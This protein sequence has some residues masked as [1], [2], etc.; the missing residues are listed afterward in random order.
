MSKS[1]TPKPVTELAT[2]RPWRNFNRDIETENGAPV[3]ST[4]GLTDA[5]EEANA[6]LIVKAVNEYDNLMHL[7]KWSLAC[8]KN[9]D[10]SLKKALQQ[11]ISKAGVLK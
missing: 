10:T 7:C 1:P 9:H 11:A 3:G 8:M 5:E 4:Y 2:P 6:C